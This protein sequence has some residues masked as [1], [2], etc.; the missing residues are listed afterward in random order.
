[1]EYRDEVL[2]KL[3]DMGDHYHK[4]AVDDAGKMSVTSK[5]ANI[6]IRCYSEILK[7]EIKHK[8]VSVIVYI[9]QTF[10]NKVL[11]SEAYF[12][13]QGYCLENDL[14]AETRNHFYDKVSKLPFIEYK[15][16]SNGRF[17]IPE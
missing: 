6:S 2:D 5:A 8:P 10:Q 1:M 17:F 14:E 16:E 7:S 9:M 4:L 11:R 3:K 15:R 13:Y 12:K